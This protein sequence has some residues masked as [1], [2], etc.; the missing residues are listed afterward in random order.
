[1]VDESLADLPL[2]RTAGEGGAGRSLAT[3]EGQRNRRAG[4]P[5]RSTSNAR[6]L[7]RRATDTERRLW[8]ILRSR[9][10]GGY[11]FRRQ[12]PV[13]PFVLDFACTKY[14]LA[15]EADGSQHADNT[16]D[17]HRTEWLEQRGWRVLRFWNTDVL[18]NTAGVAEVILHALQEREALTLPRL[19]RGPLPLPRC[20]R[21][22]DDIG[23]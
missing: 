1:M 22:E 21:G 3:G 9:Q 4:P 6:A 8:T 10:L 11:K 23:R 19:R 5:P 15:I 16:H 20:G 18:T 17:H 7:R 2:F 12:L 13:G 14:L